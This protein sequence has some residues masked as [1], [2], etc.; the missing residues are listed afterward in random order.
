[1]E[2]MD[3]F[4][5]LAQDEFSPAAIFSNPTINLKDLFQRPKDGRQESNGKKPIELNWQHTINTDEEPIIT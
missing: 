1:M 4:R 2:E 3:K 5:S